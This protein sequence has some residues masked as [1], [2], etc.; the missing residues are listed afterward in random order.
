MN[1]GAISTLTPSRYFPGDRHWSDLSLCMIVGK[2]NIFE[3]DGCNE[4][5]SLVSDSRLNFLAVSVRVT[6]RCNHLQLFCI[7]V[8]HDVPIFF[9]EATR[10]KSGESPKH[11][12]E[13]G[14]QLGHLV[15]GTGKDCQF[16]TDS[17]EMAPTTLMMGRDTGIARVVITDKN[18]GVRASFQYLLWHSLASG[19]FNGVV[20]CFLRGKEPAPVVV[21][22]YSP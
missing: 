16:M 2:R 5:G 8:I 4:I 6:S 17:K 22:L 21:S 13:F 12:G 10:D 1:G 9:V 18:R 11:I 14:V 20:R 3:K 7:S 15:R 19:F